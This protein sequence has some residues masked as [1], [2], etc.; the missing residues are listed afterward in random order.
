MTVAVAG[1]P[2]QE[3]NVASS[4]GDHLGVINGPENGSDKGCSRSGIN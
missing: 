3:R 2:L 4:V 1:H